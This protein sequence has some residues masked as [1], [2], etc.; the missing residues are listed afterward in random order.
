[1]LIFLELR[2]MVE[3][4]PVDF[5]AHFDRIFWQARL[6]HIP[7]DPFYHEE[8][9]RDAL[10]AVAHNTHG[11]ELNTKLLGNEPNWHGIIRLML[12][13][14]REVGGSAGPRELRCPSRP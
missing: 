10:A 9:I 6:L 7:F 13:W 1:M 3:S 2:Q 12:G 8:V 14:Y 5:V 4:F 11:L